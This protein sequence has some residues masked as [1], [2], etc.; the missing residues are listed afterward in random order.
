MRPRVTLFSAAVIVLVAMYL[1]LRFGISYLSQAITG[2]EN[3]LPAPSALLTI[4][5]V[6][7][8]IGLAVYVSMNE[9]NQ[10]AF[11]G[12]VVRFLRGPERVATQGD[13][14]HRWSRWG[15]LGV[16]PVLVA[17]IVYTQAL[18]AAGTPTSLRIQHPGLPKAF[19]EVE[20][21]LRTDDQGN[22]VDEATLAGFVTEGR[23]LFYINCR[24]CHGTKADGAGPMARGFRLRPADFTDPGTI[25]TVIEAFPFWRIKKGNPGLPV[26]STPWD[27]AM[28]TWERDLTDDQ[29]W[30]IILAEYDIAHVDPRIPE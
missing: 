6:L 21:P 4:Y 1:V 30:K 26:E 23:D 2:A 13:R 7:V 17:L 9:E 19:E 28:P 20:N 8:I 22:P 24:P 10:Q 29:I 12:P 18:P 11:M 25:A 5:L 16:A 14:V 3:P 27:S 15:V